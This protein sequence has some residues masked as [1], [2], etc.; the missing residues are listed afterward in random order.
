MKNIWL[1]SEG[2]HSRRL[3]GGGGC[4]ISSCVADI[5]E[6]LGQARWVERWW[7]ATAV[8]ALWPLARILNPRF[9]VLPLKCLKSCMDLGSLEQYLIHSRKAPQPQL[10]YRSYCTIISSLNHPALLDQEENG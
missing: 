10:G 5:G 4:S 6:S 2:E 7:N 1:R 3:D 8:G 9:S